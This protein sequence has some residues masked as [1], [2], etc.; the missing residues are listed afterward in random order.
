MK[1]VDCVGDGFMSKLFSIIRMNYLRHCFAHTLQHIYGTFTQIVRLGSIFA[2]F[3]TKATRE[4]LKWQRF[5]LWQITWS[6]VVD[7]AWV[8]SACVSFLEKTKI[9]YWVE[10]ILINGLNYWEKKTE[11]Q[12]VKLEKNSSKI[13]RSQWFRTGF[14]IQQKLFIF[15]T[16]SIFLLRIQLNRFQLSIK[17]QCVNELNTQNS[18]YFRHALVQIAFLPSY[19]L[20]LHSDYFSLR[21]CFRWASKF[22]WH[23][24]L[25]ISI[26]K[27][28]SRW[29][30]EI[31]V[32]S[33]LF[34]LLV[35]FLQVV[36]RLFPS[37]FFYRFYSIARAALLCTVQI[38]C[39]GLF[40]S[41]RCC[42]NFF[43]LDRTLL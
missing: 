22:N 24:T 42:S 7:K 28:S 19:S 1:I 2:L 32:F 20:M 21:D 5:F 9:C 33:F 43:L 37:P 10:F 36:L 11:Q 25:T 18:S 14:K 6:I 3:F 15:Q 16:L 39:L 31:W 41:S 17:S 35:Y 4:F 38:R 23:N 27:Y 40:L 8:E 12:Y 29:S 30:R 34:L 26:T 13:T